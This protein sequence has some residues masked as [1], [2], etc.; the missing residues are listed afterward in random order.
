MPSSFSPLCLDLMEESGAPPVIHVI[1]IEGLIGAGKSTVIEGVRRCLPNVVSV[2]ERV[3]AW[4]GTEEWREA[5]CSD[6]NKINTLQ[7]FY[8]SP[9][10]G[11]HTLQTLVLHTRMHDLTKA[12]ARARLVA[13]Q[14]EEG[15]AIVVTERSLESDRIFAK[16]A[17]EQGHMT[18]GEWYAYNVMWQDGMEATR[19]YHRGHVVLDVDVD[20]SQERIASRSRVEE[21]R[22]SDA[23][24]R[25][26]A[27]SHREIFL[28]DAEWICN[29]QHENAAATVVDKVIDAIHKKVKVIDNK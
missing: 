1:S 16:H 5:R 10:H 3:A 25:H 13:K 20:T 12:L 6:V 24:L 28:D 23:Y 11:A 9:R 8:N 18:P 14:C 21:A 4:R 29:R 27:E 26:L 19:P 17:F 15:W 22:V 7:L 2:P